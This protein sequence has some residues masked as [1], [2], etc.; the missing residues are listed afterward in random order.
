MDDL[1]GGLAGKGHCSVALEEETV[2]ELTRVYSQLRLLAAA[3]V[4]ANRERGNPNVQQWGKLKPPWGGDPIPHY[5]LK[6]TPSHWRL[7]FIADQAT[8][9][10]ILLHAVQK[11]RDARDPEDLQR[12]QHIL[13]QLVDPDRGGIDTF[14]LPPG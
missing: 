9:R 8:Q 1:R 6:T 5:V 11:K 12:S 10:I 4:P 3:G 13:E 7:Y 14:P 2:R